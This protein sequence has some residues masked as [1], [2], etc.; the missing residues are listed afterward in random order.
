MVFHAMHKDNNLCIRIAVLGYIF[1]VL[2]IYIDE[3]DRYCLRFVVVVELMEN[4]TTDDDDYDYMVGICMC[5]LQR[6]DE[7][8]KAVRLTMRER[9]FI[10]FAS[11]D[12]HGQ[13]YMTPQDFLDSVVESEPR[14]EFF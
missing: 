10:K 4:G 12:V 14:R 13:L 1:Y 7:A 6:D 11:V 2:Y 5:L 9:R 8:Q 3:R